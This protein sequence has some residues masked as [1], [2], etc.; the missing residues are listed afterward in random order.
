MGICGIRVDEVVSIL[1]SRVDE[2]VSICSGSFE[3][4]LKTNNLKYSKLSWDRLLRSKHC[5]LLIVGA[6]LFI[7][8]LN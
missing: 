1:D 7:N 8:S 4:E 2:V 3:N 6:N 5:K